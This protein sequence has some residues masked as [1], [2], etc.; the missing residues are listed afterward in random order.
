MGKL[1]IDSYEDFVGFPSIIGID[2]CGYG[3]GAGPLVMAAVDLPKGFHNELIRDS[4]KLTHEKRVLAKELIIANAVKYQVSSASVKYI[5]KYGIKSAI[6]LCLSEL[7]TTF[8]DSF[9]L[10]DGIIWYGEETH[11]HTCIAKG[12][13]VYSCIAAASILAK[14]ARDD[15]MVKLN[16]HCPGYGFNDNKGYLTGSHRKSLLEIG[17]SDYH[18]TQ[19]V[20]TWLKKQNV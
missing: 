19:Y 2:E 7:T 14:V 9:I 3:A 18:R 4:K 17:V 20:N 15:Y 5:N 12:D 8:K 11:P 10:M 13:D 6:Q 16:D 1:L